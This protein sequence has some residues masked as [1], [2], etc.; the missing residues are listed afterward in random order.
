MV[1]FYNMNADYYKEVVD[2]E[3]RDYF[4]HDLANDQS[5]ANTKDLG[6]TAHDLLMIKRKVET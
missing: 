3:K 6:A 4:K 2:I 1:E 5:K